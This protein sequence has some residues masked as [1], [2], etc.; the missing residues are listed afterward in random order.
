MARVKTRIAS[1]G[2]ALWGLIA[3]SIFYP[4]KWYFEK[5]LKTMRTDRKGWDANPKNQER[6]LA[7]LEAQGRAKGQKA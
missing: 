7:L 2:L 6:H 5:N 1:I 3:F 4:L